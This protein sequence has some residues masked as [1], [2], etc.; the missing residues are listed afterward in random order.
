MM[1]VI[2]HYRDGYSVPDGYTPLYVGPLFTDTEKDNINHLNPYINELT[3]LYY[4]WKNTNDPIAG[5]C[6]YHRFFTHNEEPMDLAYM[7]DL[8]KD[9]D[10]VLAFPVIYDTSVISNLEHDFREDLPTFHKY[11]DILYEKESGLKEYFQG[12]TFHPRNMFIAK[13]EVLEGYCNWLFPLIVPITEQFIRD[14]VNKWGLGHYY[15][16]MIGFIAERL[17]TYH[18]RKNVLNYTTAF[19]SDL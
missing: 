8:I 6:H 16:R 7:E 5:M 19:Y 18:V 9:H 14:D 3:G 11:M 17:L 10:I 15:R 13:R 1:Y 2:K 4:L 12:N